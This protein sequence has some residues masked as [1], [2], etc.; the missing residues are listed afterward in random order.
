MHVTT[1]LLEELGFGK[2]DERPEGFLGL[3]VVG[4]ISRIAGVKAAVAAQEMELIPVNP[5][6]AVATGSGFFAATLTK[7]FRAKE[8]FIIREPFEGPEVIAVAG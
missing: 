6:D 2:K 1:T 5:E 7:N 4:G 8:S 3:I